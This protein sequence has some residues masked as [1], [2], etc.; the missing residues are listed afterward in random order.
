MNEAPEPTPD[1]IIPETIARD[2]QTLLSQPTKVQSSDN[3]I[4][5]T[6][7]DLLRLICFFVVIC[8]HYV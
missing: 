8:Y 7:I 6:F 5:I 4:R 3:K 2:N 1:N